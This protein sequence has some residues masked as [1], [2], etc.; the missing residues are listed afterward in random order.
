[1]NEKFKVAE[2]FWRRQTFE[3]HPV[4]GWWHIKNLYA[5][6]P[7]GGLTH[8]FYSNSIGMRSSREYTALPV[9]NKK[10]IIFFGDSYTAGDGVSNEHRFSDLLEMNYPNLEVMN[11]GLNGSG[12]DQQ[13][14]IYESLSKE[15]EADAYVF[16]VC[17]ENIVRNFCTCRPSFDFKEHK[18]VYRPKPYFEIVHDQLILRNNPVPREKRSKDSLGDWTCNFPYLENYPKD[19][20]AVYNF[21]EGPYWLLMKKI[22]QNFMDQVVPKPVFIVPMPMLDHYLERSPA[23]YWP[24][25]KSL[26]DKKNKRYVIDILTAL[27]SSPQRKN[28]YFYNDPHYTESAHALIAKV[29]DYNLH[30]FHPELFKKRDL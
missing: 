3:Y 11:F 7:L 1:M 2:N 25:F 24:R 28:F 27:K 10:R 18:L 14:L 9:N 23:S 6:I 26:E 29:L 12:T 13:L 19:P 21:E 4:I 15:Y 8:N 30:R 20:Y 16:C 22:V 17:V 5:K